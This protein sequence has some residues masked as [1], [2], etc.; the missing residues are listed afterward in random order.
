ML[1]ELCFRLERK[2]A[3]LVWRAR[4]VLMSSI[5]KL[6]MVDFNIDE[7]R[8][9]LTGGDG[10]QAGGQGWGQGQVPQCA[11]EGLLDSGR[12]LKSRHHSGGFVM[13]LPGQV[14]PLRPPSVEGG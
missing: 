3:G 1:E 11:A 14:G 12:R 9:S 13:V 8:T 7:C 5:L 2:E 10:R 4:P 6:I